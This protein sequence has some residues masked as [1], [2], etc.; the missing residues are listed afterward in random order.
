MANLSQKKR[1][2][3]LAFLSELKEQ[4][5]DDKSLIA[6]NEIEKELVA[7]KYGLVWEEHE[8][9]VDVRM[10]TQIPVF[11][12]V[13][14]KEIAEAPDVCSYNFLLEG[15]NLHSLKLLKKTHKGKI[16]VIYIDPPYN[17]GNKD[18]RYE[19]AF[20]DKID[21]FKHSKW[22]SFMSSRLRIAHSLLSPN[23]VIFISIDD[24]EQAPLRM[25]CD[26]IFGE[27]CFVA[28][29]SWQRT[30]S[31]RNDVKG[32]AA[33]V[34]YIL[35]YGKLPDW[36]PKKLAR[37]EK[38][39]SKYKNPDNDPRGA[40][41]NI[42]ASAPNAS[43]HQGM[44]YAIQNPLTGEYAYPPQGRCWALGQEFMLDAM[45]QWAE[46]E[47]KDISDEEERA[48]V[49]GVSVSDV[50]K[51]VCA[52]V[53]KESLEN[54]SE[55][56]KQIMEG[57]LPEFYFSKKGTGTLSRK[58]YIKEVSGRPVTNFW[59]YEETG[60]TDEAS[61]LLKSIFGG[62]AVFDTPKPPRLIDRILQIASNPDSVI[63]DFF[64][65]SGTTGEAVLELNQQDG[66]RRTFI[67]CTNNEN[68][69]CE[70]I[71]YQRLKT[72]ITGKRNDG[73]VYSDGIPANLM[74]YRTDYVE[75]DN[76]G[77][78]DDLLEHIVEMIQIQYAVKV[79][80]KK[81]VLIMD[82]E[83]MDEFES[84][85]SADSDIKAIFVNQDVLLSSSQER[86]LRELNTFTVPDCYF[87][88]ELR[89]VGEIW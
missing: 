81:Y 80:N 69:I 49:C 52:I 40:W 30:Y 57:V 41:R 32:I 76:E 50:R 74:Y 84:N 31:M 59:S 70:K 62:N 55:K 68:E 53:L 67:L 71:T 60:H 20:V 63:L 2:K 77:L 35:V 5:N 33:E 14:E 9:D 3:M 21:G 1:D 82:D 61:R 42:V 78:S 56:A 4:H 29:I 39:D 37:T 73:S 24:N 83:D 43:T 38:M 75:K 26:E 7:R 25:L 86:L 28:N 48:R 89:E 34:E 51:D 79:D 17:T 18:F 11:S 64:A 66:G 15:D 23:G 87:D 6:L 12:E 65:G 85:I 72:I 13:H 58:A 10:K 47:L 46:Y 88:F 27:A 44:V 36:Q 22:L 45:G 8:E 19:D 54:A 16:D